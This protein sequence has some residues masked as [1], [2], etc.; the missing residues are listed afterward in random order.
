[1]RLF[2][3]VELAAKEIPWF[4]S[5]AMAQFLNP[6]A[7][8]FC[9]NLVTN[10]YEPMSH[11]NVLPRHKLIY[12]V[13]PK[14]ASTRIR[15]TLATVEGRLS[16]SLR[17][18]PPKYRGP[19]G[20]RNISIGSFFELATSPNTLRFSFVRNPYARAVSCWANK[21]SEKPLVRG[22][23]LINAYLAL[24]CEID[25]TL[26]AGDDRTL[27]FAEFVLFVSSIATARIN[28]HFQVQND[29]VRVP[30]M[31]LDLIGRVESFDFDFSRVLDHL[32][33]RDEIRRDATLTINKSCHKK[34]SN[35]YTP[36]LADRI[37]RAYEQDFD[38]FHYARS[39]AP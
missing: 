14:A 7:V 35:Y 12:V 26:P 10:G 4:A 6:A 19:Y 1:M 37:Y 39:I 18:D 15:K 3:P 5:R 13:V 34:W 32:G 17:S 36:E 30:G 2:R 11:L 27:S 23:T 33:A 38:C 24:R 21:F 9:N 25:A 31:N 16:R 20:P 22:D 28:S 29:I 8:V